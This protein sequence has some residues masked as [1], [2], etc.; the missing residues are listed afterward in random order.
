[1]DEE[2]KKVLDA[3]LDDDES[4]LVKKRRLEKIKSIV[5]NAKTEITEL[6]EKLEE[7]FE[8]KVE[9]KPTIKVP[10]LT[11]VEI[12]VLKAIIKHGANIKKI[13]KETGFPE[14]VI[15]RSAERLVEQGFLDEYLNPTEK[16]LRMT[17]VLEE[18]RK[19]N[20]KLIDVAIII[21]ALALFL[22]TLHYFGYI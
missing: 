11:D 7:R 19:I 4:L 10:F 20:V 6:E 13:A 21:S 8:E 12:R 3:L 17:G 15:R 16:A 2:R 18:G 1:M 5:E 9:K 22:S 14:I